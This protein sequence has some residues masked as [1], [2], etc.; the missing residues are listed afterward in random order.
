MVV[1]EMENGKKIKLEL[2]SSAAPITVENFEKL[3]RDGFY[4]GLTFHRVIS[5]FMIQG[6]CP[7]GT[8]TGGPGHTIKG[9]FKS[10]GVDN[11]IRHTRGVISMARSM[12]PN[13]AGSQFFIMHK[14][15]P[16]L[17]GQYA[18]F[19]KVVEGIEVVDEIAAVD[20]DYSDK[21]KTPVVMKKVTIE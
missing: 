4:D 19:G 17:D 20:T 8:G 21:P 15:A 11:P 3:V 7:Q 10:N 16:H 12:M 5:G 6:G 1:I 2:D 13:S 14:D 18:A 9:E